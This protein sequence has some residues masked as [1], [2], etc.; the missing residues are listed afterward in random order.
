MG[1]APDSTRRLVLLGI[2][3]S[4][5]GEAVERLVNVANGDILERT[6]AKPGESLVERTV[7]NVAG[8][9]AIDR[10]TIAAQSGRTRVRDASGVVMSFA[11]D[12]R[13][14]AVD[15]QVERP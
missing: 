10:V 5:T 9:P 14:R 1:P 8:L 3:R 4:T 11:S 13:G 15:V 12:E 6:L 7:R 2:V